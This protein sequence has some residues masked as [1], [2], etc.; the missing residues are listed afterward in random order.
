MLDLESRWRR[1]FDENESNL[2]LK[3]KAIWLQKG[4]ENTKYF[5]NF[6]NRRRLNNSIWEVKHDQESLV[7]DLRSIKSVVNKY[8]SNIYR[9][10]K[11]SNICDQLNTIQAL[12]LLL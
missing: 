2:R 10:P 1:I 4:D 8:L 9:D 3:D 5:H 11:S 6:T 7:Y 12:P